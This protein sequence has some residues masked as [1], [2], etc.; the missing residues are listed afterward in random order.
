MDHHGA[1]RHS[2]KALCADLVALF[3]QPIGHGSPTV[4]R[5]CES[6]LI[7]VR[8][9]HRGQRAA[10]GHALLQPRQRGVGLPSCV[11]SG[12]LL[13]RVRLRRRQIRFHPATWSSRRWNSNSATTSPAVT[14]LPT[15]A[16]VTRVTAA[17]P[18]RWVPRSSGAWICT[19][20]D[21]P[22][23]SPIHNDLTSLPVAATA[24]RA[25]GDW[26]SAESPAAD[27]LQLHG[28]GSGRLIP[29]DWPVRIQG[30]LHRP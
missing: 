7:P 21:A 17:R 11:R 1:T 24:V 8:A 10:H 16:S 15:S 3:F 2:R 6:R 30:N 26:H 19:E 14:G 25:G 12:A 28:P 22:T 5:R 20:R 23:V 27:T 29:A 13:A 18:T 9:G 4:E